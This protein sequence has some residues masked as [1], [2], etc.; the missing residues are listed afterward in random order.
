MKFSYLNKK[1]LFS[2]NHSSNK[3]YNELG[4]YTG[5]DN[6]SELQSNSDIT[7]QPAGWVDINNNNMLDLTDL[8]YMVQNNLFTDL[9]FGDWTSTQNPWNF[10]NNMLTDDSFESR[11]LNFIGN[12]QNLYFSLILTLINLQTLLYVY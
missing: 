6:H 5:T 8:V 11:V 12:G 7:Q 4:G 9:P 1:D 3:Y 2:S 10:T